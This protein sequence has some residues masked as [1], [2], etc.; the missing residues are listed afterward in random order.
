MNFPSLSVEDQAK[1][2]PEI[3]QRVRLVNILKEISMNPQTIASPIYPQSMQQSPPP[4]TPYPAPNP[5][6]KTMDMFDF[7]PC[8]NKS[9]SMHKC[10]D[11]CLQTYFNCPEK[12][13]DRTHRCNVECV[14]KYAPVQTGSVIIV[15]TTTS[16]I[17]NQQ[18]NDKNSKQ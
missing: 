14:R 12:I 5:T 11:Y 8:P 10:S 18:S 7:V 13:H 6:P 4:Y 17:S 3:G 16:K 9:N 15:Q 1:L 2:V